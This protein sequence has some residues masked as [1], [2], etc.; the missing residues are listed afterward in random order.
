MALTKAD[1]RDV[2]V[3]DA[4]E[5]KADG[6]SITA[7][8][9]YLTTTGVST[10]SGTQTVVSALAAD[11]EGLLFSSDHPVEAGDSVVIVGSTAADGTYTV[12]TIPTD[13]SVTVVEAIP[14]STGG[15]L[16]WVY[17]PGASR[18][19][20]K[21]TQ[22]N[23]TTSNLGQQVL[24]DLANHELLDNE[25][26][27]TGITYTVTRVGSSVSQEKWANT[28]SALTIK[29][30]DYTYTSGKVTTEV[31]KV[32]S[33]ADGTTVIAQATLTYSYSGSNVTGAVIVRN[34]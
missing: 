25:P 30:I 27:G 13:T 16:S 29:T 33:P 9:I 31:R 21:P 22:Q 11:G 32:F 17:P 20:F 3:L 5:L 24:T 18:M 4:Y 28:G 12:A 1:L 10:T 15:T 8:S 23:V 34:V 14:T 2:D 19:G 6:R 26:V 7:Y